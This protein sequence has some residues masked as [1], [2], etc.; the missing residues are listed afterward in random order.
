MVRRRAVE[1]DGHGE[2]GL[3]RDR[4][5]VGVHRVTV[6]VIVPGRSPRGRGR[7]RAAG[8]GRR[9]HRRHRR[10]RC[11]PRSRRGRTR[12][13]AGC[14]HRGRHSA[15]APGR[16]SS[17]GATVAGEVLA[18]GDVRGCRTLASWRGP[19]ANARPTAPTR[20]AAPRK[21]R[22][23]PR[24]VAPRAGGGLARAGPGAAGRPGPGSG[25]T[26]EK[27]NGGGGTAVS[28]P[29][30]RRTRLRGGERRHAR[31]RRH[32]RHGLGR[33]GV[34]AGL[35]ADGI[36]GGLGHGAAPV[37]WWL[38][39]GCGSAWRVAGDAGRGQAPAGGGAG[40]Q[41]R[42]VVDR[43]REAQALGA[44]RDGGVDADDGA[45]RVEQ[46]A[47]AVAGV[48]GGVGLDQ[49]LERRGAA[50]LLVLDGDGAAEAGHDAPGDGLGVGAERAADGDGGLADLDRAR[51]ADPRR[52]SGRSP[53][54]LMR[55]RSFVSDCSTSV[56]GYVSPSLELHGR[57]WSC[58]RRR[59]GW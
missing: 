11:G 24:P 42:R 55:A 5:A 41:V 57:G 43:D 56:A 2:A 35:A 49:V 28:G 47:A 36:D 31:G 33:A 21:T 26:G 30:Q 54:I 12:R 17:V 9:R 15:P 52:P 37:R 4:E 40:D 32:D 58:P 50:G 48:D 10:G 39:A 3:G 22:E 27:A 14:R 46:R 1:A 23:H 53:S 7:H 45:A 16:P 19:A 29:A 18:A 59:G 44:G 13:P 38:R 51:V 6:P 20:I 25:S 34:G 8:R